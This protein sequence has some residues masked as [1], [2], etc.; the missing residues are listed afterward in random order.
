[1]AFSGRRIRIWLAVC[2][3]FVFIFLFSFL[4]NDEANLERKMVIANKIYKKDRF[5][6]FY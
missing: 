2:M 4:I 1:M 5:Y 3:L 6:R